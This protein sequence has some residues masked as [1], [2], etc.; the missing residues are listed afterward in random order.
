VGFLFLRRFCFFFDLQIFSFDFCG[1]RKRWK[2]SS[3]DHL[4]E[5]PRQQGRDQ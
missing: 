2:G 3:H 5:A 4:D 1:M